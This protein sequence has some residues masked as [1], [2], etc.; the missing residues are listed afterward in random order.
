MILCPSRS[1]SFL[2]SLNS[3]SI[4][5]STVQGKLMVREDSDMHGPNWKHF[6]VTTRSHW[7]CHCQLIRKACILWTNW[8]HKEHQE[9]AQLLAGFSK[10]LSLICAIC[11]DLCWPHQTQT[12][13]CWSVVQFL[14][15]KSR[16]LTA[17]SCMG[18][19]C[20]SDPPTEHRT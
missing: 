1:C 4:V 20:Q 9:V 6:I 13:F 14:S 16:A 12:V 15:L 19:R 3:V 10:Q 2:F 5:V 18:C 11:W 8:Y 17:A 7:P